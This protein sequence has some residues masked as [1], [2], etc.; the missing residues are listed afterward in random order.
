MKDLNAT[1][2]MRTSLTNPC[3]IVPHIRAGVGENLL[4][5]RNFSVGRNLNP[6]VIASIC[7]FLL[8]AGNRT[9]QAQERDLDVYPYWNSYQT[10][11]TNTLYKV[12]ANRAFEQLDE[13]KKNI[14]GLNSK[15][16]W[17]DRQQYVKST[18][19]EIVG[20][21]PEKTPLNPV[22][23]DTLYQDGMRIEKLYYESRPGYY[24]TAMFCRPEKT[25]DPLPAILFCS[26]HASEGFRS[27]TYQHMIFNYVKK[28]FAVLAFDPIGQGERIRYLDENGK[29]RM[30][31]T[32]EHSYPGS[33][34]FLAGI[35]PANYFIW[36]GIRSVDYLLS[37]N[38]VDP[39]R[40]GI[41]GRSGGGTQTAY[42]AA[43]DDRIYA[44]APEC[45]ITT[46]DKLLK[47]RGPQ[48]AEQNLMYGI[49]KGIDMPDYIEVRAPKP[50]L[51]VSTTRDIFSIQ[52]VRDTYE[53]AQKAYKFLGKPTH[54]QKIE[55]DAGHAST[56]QNREATYAFFQKH[57]RNPGSSKDEEV[58]LFDLKELWVT[59]KGNLYKE[60]G[61]EDMYSLT[62]K[63]FNDQNVEQPASKV[64]LRIKII[65]LS[66]YQSDFD[67]SE[68]VFSGRT[69]YKDI[70]VEKYLVQGS[71]DYY[72]PVVWM[73]P[74]QSNNKVILWVDS[75]GKKEIGKSGGSVDRWLQSGYS[76]VLSDLSGIGE[77]GG[78]Y[79]G[80]DARIQ[81]VPLNI[82]YAGILTD[83][84][85]AALHGEEIARLRDFINRSK[86]NL[87]DLILFAGGLAGPELL[88]IAFL[89]D[90]EER[91]V[92]I[93][94]L[95]SYRSILDDREYDARYL[96]S[97]VAGGI[98]YYDIPDLINSFDNNILIVDPVNGA[99]KTYKGKE[100]PAA[101][102]SSNEND[103]FE[104]IRAWIE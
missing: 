5:R 4:V 3:F 60:W 89:E 16:A 63:D 21:F 1:I 78:G 33:Q 93:E 36:D 18:L 85:L 44:A 104:K 39:D 71:G 56:V 99:D 103:R 11:V 41:T 57:L 49:S 67:P 59:S 73:K 100:L 35:S 66:G 62:I 45:Y 17:L 72:L 81:K 6:I 23:T 55:D 53:E 84:S 9:I 32:H 65:E 50:T 102:F 54:L 83:K 80:G 75:E 58:Q 70:A 91:V 24:V 95:A 69:Q 26:G 19:A 42:I 30:G 51:I 52:G 98:Q 86:E 64:D 40:L 97:A 37:R 38:D 61:G 94:S 82:W 2:M 46:F 77:L 92:L 7:L 28:G 76:V 13:R 34:A 31:A 27:E 14:D 8:F 74:H 87:G 20:P 68:V 90:W 10:D 48:D 12:L 22:I 15:Q 25:T 47:S 101:V 96:M 43:V 79:P 29:P 88:H